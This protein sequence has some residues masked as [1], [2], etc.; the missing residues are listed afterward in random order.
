M[1]WGSME[2]KIT[3]AK[4]PL[5]HTPSLEVTADLLGTPS[6]RPT[7][8]DGA[9]WTTVPTDYQWMR[10]AFLE[11]EVLKSRDFYKSFQGRF[12]DTAHEK[13]RGVSPE[14]YLDFL[15]RTYEAYEREN[16]MM[17][18]HRREHYVQNLALVNG[19][20]MGLEPLDVLRF[21][22]RPDTRDRLVTL[23]M[24]RTDYDHTPPTSLVKQALYQDKLH[25]PEGLERNNLTA[26][27][28]PQGLHKDFHKAVSKLPDDPYQAAKMQMEWQRPRLEARG[29]SRPEILAS[30]DKVHTRN[31]K[32]G[33]YR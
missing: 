2:A 3:Y 22:N 1:L 32:I 20:K 19:C 27:G 26:R 33:V 23:S 28:I 5:K 12:F 13:G 15:A 6:A 21:G 24:D 10:I 9:K 18:P 17:F 11:E 25:A 31:E 16:C 30:E 14:Q 7:L 8:L 4:K 29:Y